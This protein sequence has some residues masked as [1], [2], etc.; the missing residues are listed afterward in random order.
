MNRAG[1]VVFLVCRTGAH[2]QEDVEG[3]NA[4]VPALPAQPHNSSRPSAFNGGMHSVTGTQQPCYLETL[5][6]VMVVLTKKGRQ[7]TATW[8]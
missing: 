4:I 7:F 1:G 2:G 5:T 8:H 3:C 6:E